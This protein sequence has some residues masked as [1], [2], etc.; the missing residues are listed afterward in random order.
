[1]TNKNPFGV[2]EVMPASAGGA[3]VIPTVPAFGDNSVGCVEQIKPGATPSADGCTVT[4]QMVNGIVSRIE[5]QDLGDIAVMWMIV[6]SFDTE[7]HGNLQGFDLV[8][9][10]L[11]PAPLSAA[12][13][14]LVDI[15]VCP[16]DQVVVADQTMAANGLRVYEG[17]SEKTTAPLGIGLKPGSS[18]GLVCY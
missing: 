2:F 9:K 14:L 11:W 17:G 6:S 4:N 1:M 18:H 15:A 5:F 7:A 16:N 3:L 13:E 12:T 8:A 10:T